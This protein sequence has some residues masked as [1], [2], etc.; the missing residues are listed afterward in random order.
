MEKKLV[1]IICFFL[2]KNNLLFFENE[3]LGH[4][5]SAVRGKKKDIKGKMRISCF[6]PCLF[7]AVFFLSPPVVFTHRKKKKPTW[8]SNPRGKKKL[9]HTKRNKK[10][11]AEFAQIIKQTF[12]RDRDTDGKV[13]ND[14]Y[15]FELLFFCH[16]IQS[17]ESRGSEQAPIRISLNA[18]FFLCKDCVWKKK[19]QTKDI[20]ICF[21]LHPSRVGR[22][23]KPYIILE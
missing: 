7:V 5:T 22:A 8:T 20:S 6:A 13:E 15:Y 19:K 14:L 10:N 12:L 21:S 1:S 4:I 2:T 11:T 16:K 18:F 9:K 17:S 3:G 23:K